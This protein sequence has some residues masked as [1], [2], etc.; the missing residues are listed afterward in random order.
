MGIFRGV[1]EIIF[2][3]AIIIFTF[4]LEAPGYL[5]LLGFGFV[6]W[7]ACDISKELRDR[8]KDSE[9]AVLE[10]RMFPFREV[11]ADLEVVF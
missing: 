4:S 1:A 2:G 6:V 5:A 8:N 9:V 3:L 11:G 7:G 10:L